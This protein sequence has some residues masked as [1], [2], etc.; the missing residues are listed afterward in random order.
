M[1]EKDVVIG[2]RTTRWQRHAVRAYALAQGKTVSDLIQERVVDAAVK[3][4][5]M[6]MQ[7]EVQDGDLHSLAQ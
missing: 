5:L 4:L 7:A 6:A 3:P 2:A 1:D